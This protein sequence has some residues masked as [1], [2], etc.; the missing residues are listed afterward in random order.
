MI[1]ATSSYAK[2]RNI[3]RMK[4]IKNLFELQWTYDF[5][6]KDEIK[7]KEYRYDTNHL[8]ILLITKIQICKP[9]TNH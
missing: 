4:F 5:Y 6:K 7:A 3:G 9:Q 2:V 8:F 1:S